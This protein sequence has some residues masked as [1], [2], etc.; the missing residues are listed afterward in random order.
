MC[1]RAPLAVIWRERKMA[2]SSEASGSFKAVEQCLVPMRRWTPPV[3]CVAWVVVV[4]ACVACRHPDWAYSHGERCVCDGA[5]G[6]GRPGRHVVPQ[7]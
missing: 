2:L 1:P 7:M 5:S 3:L 4:I 6:G